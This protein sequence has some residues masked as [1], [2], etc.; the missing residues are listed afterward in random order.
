VVTAKLRIKGV[1]AGRPIDYALWYSDVYIRR[2]GGW[3]YWLGQ[4]SLPLPAEV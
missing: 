2:A 3:C 1:R 4:A